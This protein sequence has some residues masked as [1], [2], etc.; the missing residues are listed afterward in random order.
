MNLLHRR[1]CAGLRRRLDHRLGGLFGN[2]ARAFCA[3]GERIAGF[4]FI[5]HPAASL[6]SGR[7]RRWPR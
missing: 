1:P 2:G 6:R 4:I 7:A 5:G 3:P